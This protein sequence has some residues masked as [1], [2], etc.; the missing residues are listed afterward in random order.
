MKENKDTSNEPFQGIND[1]I[2][3]GVERRHNRR[4]EFMDARLSSDE[5]R[6]LAIIAA[7]QIMA[8]R[9]ISPIERESAG[10]YLEGIFS[11]L[12]KVDDPQKYPNKYADNDIMGK[13][14]QAIYRQKGIPEPALG[15]SGRELVNENGI[16]MMT[17]TQTAAFEA[18][19]DNGVTPEFQ[20]QYL[21]DNALAE[22]YEAGQNGAATPVPKV[23]SEEIHPLE[24]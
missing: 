4:Q 3:V 20:G 7:G 9:L 17:L 22:I 23:T 11:L 12:D 15:M 5:L 21:V 8:N 1:A 10:K 2:K 16:D 13:T 24:R 18:G 19:T 6:K 14:T